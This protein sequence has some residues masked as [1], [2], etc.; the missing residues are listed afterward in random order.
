MNYL[1][2]D[3]YANMSSETLFNIGKLISDIEINYD[4]NDTF[5]LLNMLYGLY[6]GYFYDELVPTAKSFLNDEEMNRLEGIIQPIHKYP[7][8]NP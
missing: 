1:L 2:F 8:I 5:N 3:R 6:D 4:R 7:K